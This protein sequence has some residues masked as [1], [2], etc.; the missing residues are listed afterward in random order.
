M[1]PILIPFSIFLFI[2]YQHVDA[3]ILND[4]IPAGNNYEKA[5]FRLWYPDELKIIKGIAVIVPG[6]NSDG[7]GQVSDTIWQEFAQKHG[8][9][10]LG[11]WYKDYETTDTFI[12]KYANV[13]KGSGQ[14]LIDVINKFSITSGHSELLKAPLILWGASA[15]G[16]FN[17]EFVCWRPERVIA[18]IVNKGGIYYTALAPQEARTV[19]GI[20][21]IGEK[22]LEARNDI[23]KGLFS[24][25]RRAG[26]LWIY[27]PEP[28]VGH[29]F[30]QS[31]KLAII[32]F[33]EIIPLRFSDNFQY[34][35]N[36]TLKILKESD[37]LIGDHKNHTI[38]LASEIKKYDYP[39]SWFPSRITAEAWI[40]FITRQPL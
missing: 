38:S 28:E 36:K 32:F 29:E 37:G 9:A 26:A 25:N 18:F 14:A 35:D 4:S 13:S 31:K 10:L 24:M 23:I 17:Y 2:I 34:D 33:D 8:F 15:G 3:K 27:A 7:R 20:L 5:I 6:S 21:F 40:N 22:D 30:V 12:E 39:V 19:P 16:Q 1:K 11:C